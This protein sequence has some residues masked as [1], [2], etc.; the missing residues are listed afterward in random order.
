M[1][2]PFL[3]AVLT[4]L[5]AG[6]ANADVAIPKGY[7][8]ILL[9]EAVDHVPEFKVARKDGDYYL[10]AKVGRKTELFLLDI[11]DGDEGYSNFA[12]MNRADLGGLDAHVGY[13]TVSHDPNESDES[14]IQITHGNISADDRDDQECEAIGEPLLNPNE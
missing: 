9:C 2:S 10:A 5:A 7:E 12:P 6:A 13:V 11:T 3:L 4:S 1:K 14:K 8:P